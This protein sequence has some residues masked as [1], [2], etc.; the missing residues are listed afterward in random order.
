[1]TLEERQIQLEEAGV[2][3]GRDRYFKALE[4]RKPGG[5]KVL[6]L[7]NTTPGKKL[8]SSWIE[9]L[10]EGIRKWKVQAMEGHGLT[11]VRVWGPILF[12]FDEDV[13]AVTTLLVILNSE[14]RDSLTTVSQRVAEQLEIQRGFDKL[15]ETQPKIIDFFKKYSKPN[16]KKRNLKRLIARYNAAVDW[17]KQQV[18]HVGNILIAAALH[19]T[20]LF[21]VVQ[22]PHGKHMRPAIRMTPKAD[23]YVQNMHEEASLWRPVWPIMVVPP[24]DRKRD[25]SGGYLRLPT[26]VIKSHM[27]QYHSYIQADDSPCLVALN[28][29][30][31][32]A[33][34][35]NKRVLEEELYVWET[36]GGYGL[37]LRAIKVPPK[38]AD[39]S[40]KAVVDEWKKLAAKEYD[41]FHRNAGRRMTA[42]S[43]LSTIKT[44]AVEER[45]YIPWDFDWRGRMYPKTTHLHPQGEKA[46]KAVLEF[47]RG[48]KL[49]KTGLRW[50]KIHAA[51][52]FDKVPGEVDLSKRSFA[53]RVA[54]VDKNLP[55]ILD[56]ARNP[57][58]GEMF[59]TKTDAEPFMFLA[60]CF[61]LDAAL[62]NASGPENFE[63]HL[64]IS[65]D[66]SCNGLQHY[67]AIGL[68]PVAAAAV[69]LT[70][71]PAPSDT[72]A[73]VATITTDMVRRDAEDAGNKYQEIALWWLNKG[74]KAKTGLIGDGRKICKQPTMTYAYGVSLFGINDQLVDGGHVDGF[75]KPHKAARYLGGKIRQAIPQ[76]VASAAVYMDWFRSVAAVLNPHG[77]PITWTTPSGFCPVQQYMQPEYT[78]ISTAMGY[79][80][81]RDPAAQKRLDKRTQVSAIAPNA[82]H[83][84]DAAH[85]AMVVCECKRLGID[86]L[87]MVHDSYGTHAAYMD[88]LASVTREQFVRMY[89]HDVIGNWKSEVE[90]TTGV[91]LPDLPARGSLDINQVLDPDNY[92]FH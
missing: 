81:V 5:E 66:G 57:R 90:R 91:V 52:C 74:G 16:E 75:Y 34:R 9:P 18:F 49:G 64:P 3:A 13:L 51:N 80:K 17:N 7:T 42:A 24:V 53:D 46:A 15:K 84:F 36:G 35:V 59:W 11:G 68:D 82:V 19:F 72:Y 63:S 69:N 21:E 23:E 33:W 56:S 70:P 28:H 44:A 30:Q 54:W 71:S 79:V 32:T 65:I 29:L 12:Q 87:M 20:P 2:F 27:G 58:N 14:P 50:L 40:N 85:L 62:S 89:R 88:I 45:F 37:P 92:F 6:P 67:A 83:S 38:P 60:A 25:G 39:M 86:D 47:A 22:V 1:M 55:K 43:R 76:V 78:R 48:V 10:S 4:M 26:P 8:L 73:R 41:K 61:E 31:G 77:H